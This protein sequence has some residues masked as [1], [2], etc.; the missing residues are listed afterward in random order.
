MNDIKPIAVPADKS[1][2]QPQVPVSLPENDVK[3]PVKQDPSKRDQDQ[4]RRPTSR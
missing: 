3:D 4:E 1:P 2:A